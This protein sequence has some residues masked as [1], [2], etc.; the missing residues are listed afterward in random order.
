MTVGIRIRD[1]FE[2]N[3]RFLKGNSKG[4]S[5]IGF[6][7][8]KWRTLNLPHDWSIEGP[9][10]EK[11]PSGSGG[12][13]LPGGHGWYRK[14]FTLPAEY[15]GKRIVIEFD[16]VYMNST[17]WINGHKLGGHAYGYTS[18]HFD[19]TPY[20]AFGKKKNVLAVH[21]DNSKRPNTRWYSGSGIYRHVWLTITDK[22]HVAPWGAAI[23][24]VKATK[25]SATV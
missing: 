14:T 9:F 23:S 13:Y 18:F 25:S 16:G 8:S 17:V 11:D 1:R 19:L 3:W 24:T 15:D 12:G 20:L 2:R 4:A 5:E 21:V 6:N 22:I 10:D 7:D